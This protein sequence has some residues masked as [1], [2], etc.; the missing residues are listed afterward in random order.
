MA[1]AWGEGARVLPLPNTGPPWRAEEAPSVWGPRAWY[2]LHNAAI[3][4]PAAPTK[5]MR[6]AAMVRF[7]SFLQSLPC[8]ECRK[9]AAAYARK[10]PPDMRGSREYQTWAWRFHNA[11]N[12]RLS[13]PIMTPEEYQEVYRPEL[14][15]AYWPYLS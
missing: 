12:E 9:H 4:Y 15:R 14:A 8:A 3:N 2:W 6:L 1:R 13:K 10:H 7:W 5:E 11:A